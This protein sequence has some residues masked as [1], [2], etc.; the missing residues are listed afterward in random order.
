MMISQSSG[1]S[2]RLAGRGRAIAAFAAAAWLALAPLA[3]AADKTFATAE[4]AAAA[5][6][7][8]AKAH[9]RAAILAVLGNAATWIFSGD[10]TA[11][12]A[13]AARFVSDYE[14][15]HAL[16]G[17]GDRLTLTIGKED[18]P[19][20][21]P[22]VKTGKRWR[23]DTAAGKEE[24]L[25]RR[26]GENELDTIN[27][28][29]AIVDA[30]REYAARN[31]AGTAVPEYAMKFASSP[32]KRDGLYWPV[33]EG[34]PPSPL[35]ALVASAAAEGYKRGKEPAPFHGYYYRLLAGQTPNAKS[36]AVDY[37]VRGR[38]IAG[39]AAIAYPAKYGNS[40]VMTFIVNHDGTIYQADLG[41]STAATASKTR[42]FDPGKGWT[43]V[44]AS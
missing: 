33:K 8:A 39:F 18:Y 10:A 24:L 31:P 16:A 21:F 17:S 9:D 22:I 37:V 43:P 2:A 13:G 4:D 38:A 7:Q 25:K 15:K 26:I 11:D 6:V 23:F 14:A 12:R 30:E 34:E 36:G 40:G 5:L 35:G 3:Q 41:P 44:A 27:V 20:A 1:G 32:G 42:R 28:L 19:F 29:R